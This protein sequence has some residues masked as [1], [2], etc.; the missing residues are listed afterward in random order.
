VDDFRIGFFGD[1]YWE[2]AEVEALRG[3]PRRAAYFGF[4]AIR[5]AQTRPPR[6]EAEERVLAWVAR[7][8]EDLPAARAFLT[9]LRLRGNDPRPNRVDEEGMAVA[10]RL[11]EHL[12]RTR[13][14]F[15]AGD[16]LLHTRGSYRFYQ[17]EDYEA[18]EEIY[19]SAVRRYPEGETYCRCLFQLFRCRE[20]L[21]DLPGAEIAAYQVMSDCPGSLARAARR[22]L[23]GL[24]I[25]QMKE[26]EKEKKEK[27]AKE[28]SR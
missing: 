8:E 26:K 16:L 7:A 12:D 21:E 19:R 22:R 24:K 25:E 6:R 15:L 20:E 17:E 23:R 13:S 9:A 18:A 27:K 3:H 11:L 2:M 10:D 4:E 1:A 28:P 5:H 14:G